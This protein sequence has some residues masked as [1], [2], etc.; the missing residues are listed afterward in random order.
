[1]D[2]RMKFTVHVGIIFEIFTCE[3]LLD[4]LD[5]DHSCMYL[6]TKRPHDVMNE[7]IRI[8]FVEFIKRR[9]DIGDECTYP[10]FCLGTWL[11]FTCSHELTFKSGHLLNLSTSMGLSLAILK[12]ISIPSS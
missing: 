6:M 12:Y 10:S 1:M 8:S 2:P 9:L 4:S 3:N 5:P 7:L 11:I